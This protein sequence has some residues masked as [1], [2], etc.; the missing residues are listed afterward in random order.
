MQAAFDGDPTWRVTRELPDGTPYVIRP[1]SPDDREG[2]RH[3]F[4]ETS[5]HTR[6]L[7]FG[8]ASS[9]LTDEALTYLTCVDQQDHVALVATTT[10]PDLKTERGIGVA[11]FV[12][13]KENPHVAEAAVVIVDDVQRKGVGT[14]LTHELGRA[15]LLRGITRLRADVLYGNTLMRTILEQL[16][17]R[18]LTAGPFDGTITYELDLEVLAEREGFR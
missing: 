10:T 5:P 18:P 16:G 2:L 17:A 13:S 14:A 4:D 15:A 1:I 11:R 8:H 7:R 6:Y 9:T 3:G 12:R